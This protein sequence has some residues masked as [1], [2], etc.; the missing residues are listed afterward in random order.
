[1]TTIKKRFSGDIIAE[2]DGIL[3]H[4][5]EKNRANLREA[6]LR[7]ANLGE[8]NLREANLREANLRGADLR[9]ANLR[10]ADLREA[11]LGGA[12]LGGADLGGA[13]LWGANLR[14]ADLRE[15]TLRGADL[16]G[17]NLWGANLGEANLR[18]ARIEFYQYPSIR[19]LSSI[20]LGVLSDNLTLELMRRDAYGHP[21]PELFDEWAKGGDCPYQNEERLWS[22]QENRE[23]WKPGNPEMTDRD[24]VLALCKEKTWGIR[25]YLK[26]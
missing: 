15:A 3:K 24:F 17:A 18:G 11:D 6:N 10:G 12:N 1:M 25:G 22:F 26:A 8:A 23:L 13:N 16:R 4:L 20:S 14:E 5:A 9:E 21:R 7:G 2:G 19:L